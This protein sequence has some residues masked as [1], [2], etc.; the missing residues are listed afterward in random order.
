M[1]S[2]NPRG[3]SDSSV[4]RDDR[5]AF[6]ELTEDQIERAKAFGTVEDL[7]RGS[8][9]FETGQRTVDF[10][11]VLQGNI[12]IFDEA[13][14]PLAKACGEEGE[15]SGRDAEG[16][17]I[18]VHGERCFT[19]ELDLFS[20]RKILVSGRMGCDGRVL[21]V[22]RKHFRKLLAAEPD[23]GDIVMRAFILRRVGL[24]DHGQGGVLLVGRKNQSDTLR[25]QQFLR[26]NGHP[27]RP[28]CL[29]DEATRD[30]ARSVLEH[31]DKAESDMPV[32]VTLSGRALCK[33][34]NAEVAEALGLTENPEEQTVYDVAVIGAGPAGLGAAVYAAS[35][36]LKTLILEAEAPGGQ[37][38]T[39]SRI[40]NYLGF[41]T[42]VSGQEL[43]GRAQAQAQKFGATLS[44]PRGVTKLETPA[45]GDDAP[46]YKL[47]LDT[48]PPVR[49]RTAVIA[50]GA[51]WRS[52]ELPNFHQ[53]EGSGIHYAAT[54]VEAE[55]CKD[56]EIA[57][58][59]GGN[60]AGQA[61]VFLS[62]HARCVH[63]LVRGDS[64]ASSMSDYLIQR[65]E[66]SEKIN[67]HTHTE[68]TALSG[69]DWLERVTW[70]KSETDASETKP[71]QHVFLMIGA[72]PNCDWLDGTLCRDERGF[73][74]TGSDATQRNGQKSTCRRWP[75]NR[76][77]HALETSLPGVFA[78]GDVRSGSVK[79]VASAVGEG[80]I[81]VQDLH[82]VL[83]EQ[84]ER[85]NA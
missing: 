20:D 11:I 12:E 29:D 81:C 58:V 31:Y 13:C 14:D 82:R 64:L 25:I 48:G 75:L 23:V 72:V 3:P 15:S 47:H 37:A 74:V 79:R 30:A 51:R 44:L 76:P 35:E 40:E 85:A 39:S 61:A 59:G 57:V 54:A 26:R 16:R 83:L 28:L 42:G 17:V 73:L 22:D 68:I 84:Q 53:F 65:I 27:L 21:R 69:D 50:C 63:M 46:I 5:H 7:P 9:V 36:G 49:T 1:A 4:T 62:R 34:S 67:L 52:L 60:S 70:T 33:P 43:A 71:I 41:P 78:V 18:T 32:V 55:L 56:S 80:S 24:I 8:L 45:D 66:A 77:P 19:G 6:P 10:F 38:G 2:P